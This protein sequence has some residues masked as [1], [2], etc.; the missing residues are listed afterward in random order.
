MFDFSGGDSLIWD[1]SGMWVFLLVTI[2]MGG[3]TAIATGRAVASTWRPLSQ[4]IVYAAALA[5][6]ARFL[7]HALFEGY[8]VVAPAAPAK[9]LWYFAVTF[10]ILALIAAVGYRGQRASQ[11]ARQYSW[12]G[13]ASGG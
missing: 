12:I 9:G 10:V 13:S 11:M 3:M 8:F 5:V 6:A 2:V 4:A 7:H 1:K